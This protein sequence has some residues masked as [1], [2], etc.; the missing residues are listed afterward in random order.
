[1][2]INILHSQIERWLKSLGY[3]EIFANHP[4]ELIRQFHFIKNGVRLVCIIDI[5]KSISE[6]V[7]YFSSDVFSHPYYV[8][9]TSHKLPL[10]TEELE[11]MSKFIK[12]QSDKLKQ[13]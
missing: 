13:N 7:C 12:D 1:M 6:A 2:D 5:R 9:I 10:F 11:T 3:V 8:S 4:N